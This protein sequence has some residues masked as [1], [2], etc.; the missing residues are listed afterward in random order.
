MSE[1]TNRGSA[2][3]NF[4]A[5]EIQDDLAARSSNEQRRALTA[6]RDLERYYAMIKQ[7]LAKWSLSEGEASLIVDVLNGTITEPHSAALLWAEID[8]A[9]TNDGV[10][11]RWSVDGEELVYNLRRASAFEALALIDAAERYWQSVARGEE[12]SQT[13]R[14]RKVGLFH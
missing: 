8:D 13:E 14:L 7:T 10:A 12:M 3:V 11:E 1:W 4:R 2:Q 9:I 5:G 6:K